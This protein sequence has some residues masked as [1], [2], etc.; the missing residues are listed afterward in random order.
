MLFWTGARISEVLNISTRDID[1]S[2]KVVIINSLKKRNK[3]IVRQIPLPPGY[4]KQLSNS[5]SN[6]N[7]D[8]LI[9]PFSRRTALRYVKTIMKQCGIQGSKACARGLRHSFAVHCVLRDIPLNIIQKWMGHSSVS[10]TMIYL[11]IVGKEEREFAK[12][13]W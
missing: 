1:L 6:S 2:D 7:S 3:Y 12:R 13:I 4:L 11:N 10:T 5:V 8:F 9:W